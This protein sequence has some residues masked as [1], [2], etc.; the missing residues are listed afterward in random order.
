MCL[1]RVL[2]LFMKIHLI[3]HKGEIISPVS[4]ETTA[5]L[6]SGTGCKKVLNVLSCLLVNLNIFF[7]TYI[8]EIF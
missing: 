8:M 5:V 1:C 6:C 7:I 3:R 2:Q 4:I